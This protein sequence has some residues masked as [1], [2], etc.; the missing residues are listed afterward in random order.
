MTVARGS[1]AV[2]AGEECLRGT[3]AVGGTGGADTAEFIG[4]IPAELLKELSADERIGE[5]GLDVSDRVGGA[6]GAAGDGLLT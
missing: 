3:D 1:S 5:G 2:E 6:L 4:G